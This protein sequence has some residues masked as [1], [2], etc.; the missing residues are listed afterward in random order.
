MQTEMTYT[1]KHFKLPPN[2]A[3]LR[4]GKIEPYVFNDNIAIAVDIALATGRP[5]LVAGAPGSGK[6]RLAEVMATLLEWNYLYTTMTSRTRLEDLTADYDHLLRMHDAH[7]G[8]MKPDSAYLKPGIF[9]WAFNSKTASD[10]GCAA[11][12]T[13]ILKVALDYPEFGFKTENEEN[14]NKTV[15]LIDEIDKAEPDLPNDLLEPLDRYR[16]TRPDGIP[17]DAVNDMEILTIITTNRERELP[18]AFMRRCVSLVLEAPNQDQLVQIAKHHFPDLKNK[19]SFSK[20]ANAVA[21]KTIELQKEATKLNRRPPSTSEFLDALKTCKKLNI[22]V[23]H[24]N[25]QLIEQSILVKDL[26]DKNDGQAEE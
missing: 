7:I 26:S 22:N 14:R 12:E 24:A 8:K 2:N 3:L 5:L 16:F 9:W 21:K 6:S 19:K 13:E 17:V 1:P 4:T 10:R 23:E 18:A 25:W 20:L 15:L 11:E